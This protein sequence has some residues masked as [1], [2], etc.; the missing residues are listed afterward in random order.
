MQKP[1][2]IIVMGVSG[3]G[4]STVAALLAS[5]NDG[6]FYDADEFHPPANIAKMAAG[7]PLEDEDRWPWL[8]RIRAEVVDATADGSLKVL[9]CSA[10]KQSYR[11]ILGAGEPG[12]AWVYL[13]GS[14]ALLAERLEQ[15]AGHY[16]KSNLLESQLATLEEPLPDEA[17]AMDIAQPALDLVI[18]VERSLGLQ[19]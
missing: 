13:H 14:P 4:K 17:L 19:N 10:L 5:R 1:R 7:I 16:M 15:R 2:V 9:A 12:V 8:E 11:K 18:S 6:R 3:C